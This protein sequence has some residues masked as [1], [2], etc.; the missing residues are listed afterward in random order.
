[1]SITIDR[2]GRVVIPQGIRRRLGLEP[3][4]ELDVDEADGAVVLRPVSRVRIELADDGM[5]VI[6][7]AK[8][9]PPLAN[10]EVLRVLDEVREWPR[11]Y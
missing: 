2:A 4:T 6:R 10:N 11:R 7:A 3:G 9:T 5:P 8:G 1:M